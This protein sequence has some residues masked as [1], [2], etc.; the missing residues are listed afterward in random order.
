MFVESVE[1]DAGKIIQERVEGLAE[2]PFQLFYGKDM[3]R[4]CLGRDTGEPFLFTR[5][6]SDRDPAPHA[7]RSNSFKR[8]LDLRREPAGHFAREFR[9]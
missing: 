3:E 8:S 7:A 4:R 9:A 2:T 5:V 6:H 1:T